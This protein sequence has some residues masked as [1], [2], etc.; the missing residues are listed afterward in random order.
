MKKL[1]WKVVNAAMKLLVE[2]YESNDPY[3][4]DSPTARADGA[5]HRQ[6]CETCAI[7]EAYVLQKSRKK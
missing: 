7:Y 2:H 6:T 5:R 3:V 1:N 4:D